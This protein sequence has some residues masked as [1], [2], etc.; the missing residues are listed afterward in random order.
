MS[1]TLNPYLSFVDNA[2]DAMAFYQT[3]FGGDLISNTFGDFGMQGPDTDKIMHAQLTTDKG[4]TIMASD[5]PAHMEHKTGSAIT[6]SLSGNDAEL[7]DYFWQLAEG[8]T[9]DTPLEKQ[10]WGDEFGQLVDRFGVGWV[11]NLSGP[12]A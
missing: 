1:A 6:I 8:G 12:P 9:I 4:F 10:V 5:T 3:V 7:R 2:K 11:V